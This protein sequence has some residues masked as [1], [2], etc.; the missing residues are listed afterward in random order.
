VLSF[1]QP[2]TDWSA[3]KL[4]LQQGNQFFDGAHSAAVTVVASGGKLTSVPLSSL[5]PVSST[6]TL[7]V[8]LPSY[9]AHQAWQ[10]QVALWLNSPTAGIFNQ[11]F[12]PAQFQN[13]STGAFHQV[14]FNLPSSIVHALSTASYADLVASLE[15]DFNPNPK[16][17]RR[18]FRPVLYRQARLRT[19]DAR[20]RRGRR[21]R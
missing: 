2:M 13:A 18:V 17:E 15:L 14:Q 11:Y 3:S 19:G 12:G 9:L 8:R 10:G 7:Q 1:E 5:G 6:A 16:L 4:N 20:R 21:G